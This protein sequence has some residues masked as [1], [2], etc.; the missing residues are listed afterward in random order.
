MFKEGAFKS[1]PPAESC[2]K[3]NTSSSEKAVC[4][5]E[6]GGAGSTEDGLEAIV[7]W[8]IAEVGRSGAPEK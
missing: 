3:N 7:A 5:L 2:I 8:A 1:S 6:R 4:L